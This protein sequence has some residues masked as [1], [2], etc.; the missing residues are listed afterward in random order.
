MSE[1]TISLSGWV[2][3][4]TYNESHGAS[5]TEF[6]QR[7]EQAGWTFS[8]RKPQVLAVTTYRDGKPTH[9]GL[10][11]DKDYLLARIIR[12]DAGRYVV[13]GDRSISPCCTSGYDDY[14]DT[15]TDDVY[16]IASVAGHGEWAFEIDEAN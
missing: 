11:G 4:H 14:R 3:V 1:Q 16:R 13:A 12:A 7:E 8:R 6:Y 10:E 9:I 5:R 2:H 15:Q